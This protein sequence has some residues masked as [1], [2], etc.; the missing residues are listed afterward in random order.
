MD[1]PS[2]ATETPLEKIEAGLAAF[3]TGGPVKINLNDNGSPISFTANNEFGVKYNFT[4][5]GA[6]KLD[7]TPA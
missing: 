5:S 3:A 2:P 6:A 7:G 1:Q 4:F